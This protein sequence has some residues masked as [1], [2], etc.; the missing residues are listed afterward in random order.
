MIWSL[1]RSLSGSG[2]SLS[3]RLLSMRNWYASCALWSSIFSVIL[4]R[5]KPSNP[6]REMPKYFRK[7]ASEI[8]FHISMLR[9]PT[10]P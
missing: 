9:G 10:P 3:S 1:V 5:R 2:P 8:L 7:S 4:R 6:M